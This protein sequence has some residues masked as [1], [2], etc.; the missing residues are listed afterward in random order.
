[1]YRG[2]KI[3]NVSVNGKW[4]PSQLV[5]A[6]AALGEPAAQWV[7]R[8]FEIA[9]RFVQHGLVPE[10][11]VAVYGHWRG[12]IAPGSHFDHGTGLPFVQHGWVLCPFG[13]VVDPTRWVFEGVEPYVYAGPADHY[14]EG[15]NEW[16]EGREGEAPTFDQ[17]EE[18][19]TFSKSVM[20]SSDAWNFVEKLLGL[21][22]VLGDDGYEPGMM[23][24]VQLRWLA[25]RSPRSLGP[26]ALAVFTAICKLGE[27]A[28]IPIDNLKRVER[29][30]R[31][32][33]PR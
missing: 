1:M 33:L 8:C 23:T 9:S 32:E 16:R 17:D 11:S 10:G 31:T 2:G 5:A 6:E 4:P 27:R 29:E 7:S 22:N 18:T 19:V 3:T 13:S 26:H 30:N 24:V 21:H 25:H 20:P 14:D 12:P 28:L 15:G